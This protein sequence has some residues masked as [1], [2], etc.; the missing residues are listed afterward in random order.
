MPI[1]FESGFVKWFIL[2]QYIKLLRHKPQIH[3]FLEKV[4]FIKK[5]PKYP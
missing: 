4:K 2:D 5:L 1:S 3:L